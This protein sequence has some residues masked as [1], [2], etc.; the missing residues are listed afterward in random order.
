MSLLL[1]MTSKFS[2]GWGVVRTR[3]L[4]LSGTVTNGVVVDKTSVVPATMYP[5]FS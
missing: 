3:G 5:H 1:E 4:K 2:P